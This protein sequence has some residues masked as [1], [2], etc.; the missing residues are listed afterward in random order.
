MHGYKPPEI[1]TKHYVDTIVNRHWE[2]FFKQVFHSL[3]ICLV[4][5]A[6]CGIEVAE[7]Y[8]LKLRPV[9]AIVDNFDIRTNVQQVRNN[10]LHRITFHPSVHIYSDLKK[11]RI[12]Q[13]N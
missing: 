1:L 9:I 8:E 5:Y 10:T 3:G 2:V 7:N 13:D 4:T 6:W 12:A 11:G